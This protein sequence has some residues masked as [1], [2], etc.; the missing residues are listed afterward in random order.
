MKINR[1]YV[2]NMFKV[3]KIES[4]NKTFRFPNELIKKLQLVAQQKNVSLNKL[5]IQC[6]EYALN[7]LD[8]EKDK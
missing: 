8:K 6:C 1:L 5:V 2:T 4:S 3:N 7:N